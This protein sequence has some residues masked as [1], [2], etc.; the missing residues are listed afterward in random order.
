MKLW[1]FQFRK[2]VEARSAEPLVGNWDYAPHN[3][4][5]MYAWMAEQW[6]SWIGIGN[7]AATEC[8]QSAASLAHDLGYGEE[9]PVGTRA[10][11]KPMMFS[12]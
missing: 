1:T 7:M 11:R 8:S 3:W 10:N 5:Q 4:R 2:F 6:N 12:R 9:A